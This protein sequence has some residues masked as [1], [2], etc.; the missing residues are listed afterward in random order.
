LVA[1][2]DVGAVEELHGL[3]ISDLGL[4][5]ELVRSALRNPKPAIGSPADAAAFAAAL[6]LAPAAEEVPG[7][8]VGGL[9]GVAGARAVVAAAAGVVAGAARG[10]V[11][12]RLLERPRGVEA[13]LGRRLVLELLEEGADEVGPGVGA[14]A[15]VAR[16]EHDAAVVPAHPRADDEVRVHRDEPPVGAL[17]RRARLAGELDAPDVEAAA[18]ADGR[19]P[20]DDVLEYVDGGV[21]DGGV[22]HLAARGLERGDDVAVAVLDPA[23]GEL[24]LGRRR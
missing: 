19:P 24:H 20:R 8:A 9:V 17:L 2:V 1:E 16:P 5:N 14:L 18:E 22:E 23:H 4:R 12:R 3:R 13:E 10:L 6:A 21:G 7:G 11:V 15:P